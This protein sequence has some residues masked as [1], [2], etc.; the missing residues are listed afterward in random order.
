MILRN[1]HTVEN[2][3]PSLNLSIQSNMNIAIG[4]LILIIYQFQIPPSSYAKYLLNIR[5][6]K[7]PCLT[8][9]N[10]FP[11]CKKLHGQKGKAVTQ[12][13]PKNEIFESIHFFGMAMRFY[14]YMDQNLWSLV[15]RTNFM[16][17][18]MIILYYRYDVYRYHFHRITSQQ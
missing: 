7:R 1:L 16:K 8:Y 12:K 5:V 15:H 14:P 10:P 18:I 13:N 17:Y 4:Y 3:G 2:N 9:Q 6:P 11:Q